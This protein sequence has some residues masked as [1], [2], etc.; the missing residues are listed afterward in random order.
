M[1]D[2]QKQKS[3]LIVQWYRGLKRVSQIRSKLN[4]EKDRLSNCVIVVIAL[5]N[6]PLFESSHLTLNDA[7]FMASL[8]NFFSHLPRDPSLKSHQVSAARNVK[9]ITSALL[10]WYFP[11]IVLSADE[12]DVSRRRDILKCQKAA[13]MLKCAFLRLSRRILNNEKHNINSFRSALV[14]FRFSVRYFLNQ[15]DEWKKIDQRDVVKSLEDVYLDSYHTLL[16]TRSALGSMSGSEDAD[17]TRTLVEAAEDRVRY[18]EDIFVKLLGE[19]EAQQHIQQLRVRSVTYSPA[20]MSPISQISPSTSPS[21]PSPLTAAVK[22]ESSSTMLTSDSTPSPPPATSS[23]VDTAPN[24]SLNSSMSSPSSADPVLISCLPFQSVFNNQS[25]FQ[26]FYK[27]ISLSG[28][29]DSAYLVYE[30]LLN[31]TFRI[32]L[33]PTVFTSSSCSPNIESSTNTDSETVVEVPT[34][35]PFSLSPLTTAQRAEVSQLMIHSATNPFKAASLLKSSML[36]VLGDR[37][38][39]SLRDSPVVDPSQVAVGE[40]VPVV[41]ALPGSAVDMGTWGSGSVSVHLAQVTSLT[42]DKASIDVEYLADG[43]RQRSVP[44]QRIKCRHHPIDPRPLLEA[45]VDLK[46]R[47]C[48]LT[49]RR[50]DIAQE[51]TAG[52]DETL[53]AQMLVN[54]AMPAADVCRLCL[55]L[56]DAVQRLQ[57][58][59]ASETTRDWRRQFEAVCGLCESES[60]ARGSLQKVLSY[61]PG[62]FE[63]AAYCLEVVQGETADYYI[64]R[65]A[66]LLRSGPKAY[67]ALAALLQSRLASEPFGAEMPVLIEWLGRGFGSDRSVVI[68]ELAECGVALS[69]PPTGPPLATISPIGL[70]VAASSTLSPAS[71]DWRLALLVHA[72]VGLFNLPVR[73]DSIQAVLKS[74]VPESL[75]WDAARLSAIRDSVD[76]VV[77]QATMLVTVRQALTAA[78]TDAGTRHVA[79]TEDDTKELYFRLDV[80]LRDPAVFLPH[81]ATEV[82]RF[83]KARSL[84][85]ASAGDIAASRSVSWEQELERGVKAAVAPDHPV[86]SLFSKRVLRLMT[87]SLLGADISALLATHSLSSPLLKKAVLDLIQSTRRVFGHNCQVYGALYQSVLQKAVEQSRRDEVA[88]SGSS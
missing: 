31:P 54:D 71:I 14:G 68:A 50:V 18:T 43:V 4:S 51:L 48:S 16:Y 64:A 21:R 10:I 77:L 7:S 61:L 59:A 20:S 23:I 80:L 1:S 32:P 46:D 85:D 33:P 65:L 66:P 28:C 15:L 5:E 84:A 57:S 13:G 73:L 74:C 76:L 29:L 19:T 47:I 58:P 24:G 27:L 17:A 87:L 83:V 38:L 12:F 55:F 11:S 72:F 22:A 69:F 82:T 88:V 34:L 39:C 9:L 70:P 75:R 25:Q 44:I 3:S 35:K 2:A 79:L 81:L 36:R 49:P 67:E 41:M 62:F 26:I 42:E 63:Y 56:L 45:L 30:M 37:L 8:A 60:T 6:N 78:P 86:L 52:L 53:I 40:V